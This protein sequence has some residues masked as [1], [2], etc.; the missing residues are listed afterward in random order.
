MENLEF[1]NEFN[2]LVRMM[3]INSLWHAMKLCASLPTVL[4]SEAKGRG[5]DP[6]QP[7]QS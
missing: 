1:P 6:R 4:L 3:Q 5:F 7:H 2:T